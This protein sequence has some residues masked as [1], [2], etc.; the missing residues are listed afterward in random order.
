MNFVSN[1]NKNFELKWY[2]YF[3]LFW[4]LGLLVKKK[5]NFELLVDILIGIFFLKCVIF[6]KY[7]II[8]VKKS[9]Y[10]GYVL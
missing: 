6:L 9:L 1:N 3:I 5:Y 2:I 8:D 4:K 7:V 10:F